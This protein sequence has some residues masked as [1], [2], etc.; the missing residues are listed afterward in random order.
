MGAGLAAENVKLLLLLVL[1]QGQYIW[2]PEDFAGRHV[3][4]WHH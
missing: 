1:K 2:A 3:S 4:G